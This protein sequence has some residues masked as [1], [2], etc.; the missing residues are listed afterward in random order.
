MKKKLLIGILV[1]IMAFSIVGCE[2]PEDKG[3]EASKAETKD[4]NK[5]LNEMQRQVGQPDIK[6]FFEKKLAKRIYEKRDDSSLVTYVYNYS[7]YLGKYIFNY[8]AVGFGLP[9]SV[10]YINPDKPIDPDDYIEG[11]VYDDG[12]LVITQPEPNGLYMPDSVEATW[13]LRLKEDGNT[14][15]VYTEPRTKVVQSPLPK[16]IVV[17]SSL[18]KDMK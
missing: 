17:K 8:K 6:N 1:V 14:E 10:Q 16:R 12:G 11:E 9:Y 5:K 4:M 18:P 15:V 7:P 2:V 13:L 3:S